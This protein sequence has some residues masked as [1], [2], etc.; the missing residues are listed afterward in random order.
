MR[1]TFL[2]TA[3]LVV[4]FA[5]PAFAQSY[6][7]DVGSGNLDAAPYATDWNAT[8]HVAETARV[9][10]RV[11]RRA[12]PSDAFAQVPEASQPTVWGFPAGY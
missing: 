1:K 11:V 6:D 12:S 2:V 3:A 10:R 7:P 8:N 9:H 5:A 4:A